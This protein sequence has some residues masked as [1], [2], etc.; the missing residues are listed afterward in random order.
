MHT[1]KYFNLDDY[2]VNS[3]TPWVLVDGTNTMLLLHSSQ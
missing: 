3:L 2:K 1:L